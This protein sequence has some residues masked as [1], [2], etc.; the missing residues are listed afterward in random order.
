MKLQ[1]L[2]DLSVKIRKPREIEFINLFRIE[3]ADWIS[4]A[5]CVSHRDLLFL[6]DH[7]TIT[8]LVDTYGD[9]NV[10]EIFTWEA[11]V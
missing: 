8:V 5:V 7:G 6:C 3:G 11:D 10:G 2:I 1:D 4:Y 9:R